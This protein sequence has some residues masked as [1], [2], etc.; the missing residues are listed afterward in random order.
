[1]KACGC[2]RA[3][4]RPQNNVSAMGVQ[5]ACNVPKSRAIQFKEGLFSAIL[6]TSIRDNGECT[7]RGNINTNPLE[8]L[9]ECESILPCRACRV[10]FSFFL[11]DGRRGVLLR[12][13]QPVFKIFVMASRRGVCVVFRR[14]ASK[15][16]RHYNLP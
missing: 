15:V 14:G 16:L 5:A 10:S 4:S 6:R 1:M 8:N 9:Y 12:R 2:A 7:L 3:L 13:Q 11:F